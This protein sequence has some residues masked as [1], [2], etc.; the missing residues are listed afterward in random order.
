MC[1]FLSE[2][3]WLLFFRSSE[4]LLPAGMGR[5]GNTISSV[6][7]KLR[8]EKKPRKQKNIKQPQEYLWEFSSERNVMDLVFCLGFHNLRIY[9]FILWQFSE[10]HFESCYIWTLLLY[11]LFLL[12]GV[13][14]APFFLCLKCS[15]LTPKSAVWKLARKFNGTIKQSLVCL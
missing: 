4:H 1:I 2:I 15:D 8:K 7:Q 9:E 14:S 6:P 13:K 3:R 12:W 10:G 5:N 11:Q